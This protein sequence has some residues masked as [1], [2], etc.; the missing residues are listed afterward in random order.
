[1]ATDDA[2]AAAPAADPAAA[3]DSAA[4]VRSAAEAEFD[5]LTGRLGID[6]PADLKGGVLAGYQGLRDMAALLRSVETDH[7]GRPG[8][9]DDRTGN[10][11]ERPGA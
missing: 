6:V 5:A 8:G 9:R 1:M 3:V 7:R 10:D 2:G 4:A 11:E